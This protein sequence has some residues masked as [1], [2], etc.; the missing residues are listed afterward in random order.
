MTRFKPRNWLIVFTPLF[1]VIGTWTLVWLYQDFASKTK[2]QVEAV[3]ILT[4][5]IGLVF[6]GL[7]IGI[8]ICLRTII[9][10]K[11]V[12][13]INYPFQKRTVRFD[14]DDINE[15]E[16]LQSVGGLHVPTHEILKIKTIENRKINFSSLEI[17]NYRK[18]KELMI[19]DYKG[20][21]IMSEYG[22]PKPRLTTER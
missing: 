18:L 21:V 8:F 15:V 5:L 7:P 3:Y 9:R 20:K 19:K 22:K 10:D 13:T 2:N 14:K 17:R 12:W 6:I 4:P 1:L 11:G 16:I